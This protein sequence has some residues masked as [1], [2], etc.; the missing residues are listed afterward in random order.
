MRKT[1][2]S[3]ILSICLFGCSFDSYFKRRHV[4]ECFGKVKAIQPIPDYRDYWQTPRETEKWKTGDC[5]DKAFYLNKM[6]K[7]KGI[8][9]RVVF[10]LQHEW[11]LRPWHVWVEYKLDGETFILD[12][13]N[14]NINVRINK[15]DK[16]P[17]R[18]LELGVDIKDE[19][20][21]EGLDK[22]LGWYSRR[23]EMEKS[24]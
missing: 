10:G 23:L 13:I 17:Q 21:E 1:L 14:Q 2:V 9:S 18:Y 15:K 3:L 8:E 19:K 4:D 24:K 12:P 11:I 6:L 22:K 7:E 5:E 16:M 20:A